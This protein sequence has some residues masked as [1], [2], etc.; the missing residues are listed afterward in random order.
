MGSAYL[1]STEIEY[2]ET[3]FALLTIYPRNISIVGRFF[4]WRVNRS[5][6]VFGNLWENI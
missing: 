6:Y 3:L 1:L 4:M 5:I 2:M